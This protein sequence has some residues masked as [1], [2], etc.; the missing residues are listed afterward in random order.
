MKHLLEVSLIAITLAT[1]STHPAAGQSASS[2]AVP[3]LRKGIR[4][5]LPRTTSA[6]SIPEADNLDALVV[7]IKPDGTT[8]LGTNAIGPA[9]L[10]KVLASTVKKDVYIKA[11][12]HTSYA[13][14][15]SILDSLHAAGIDG[16]TFLT[17]Q[18]TAHT[19]GGL[20]PPQGLALRMVTP[21]PLL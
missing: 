7:T 9:E 21:R 1:I 20:L 14:V 17:T 12:A 13:S 8:Y 18:Q 10:N 2:N 15:V 16:V 3:H 19:S 11:D 4:V 5:D 6:A